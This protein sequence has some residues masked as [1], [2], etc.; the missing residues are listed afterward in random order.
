ME[1]ME[2]SAKNYEAIH[3][4][5]NCVRIWKQQM[6]RVIIFMNNNVIICHLEAIMTLL[7]IIT[8]H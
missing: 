8:R 4:I 3:A 5:E 1:D 2:K 7:F 6:E